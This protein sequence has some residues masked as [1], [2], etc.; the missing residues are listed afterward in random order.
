MRIRDSTELAEVLAYR[1][2]GLMVN[3]VTAGR[4]AT[5]TFNAVATTGGIYG[6]CYE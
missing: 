2:L 4:P 5:A 1:I 3:R 6:Y